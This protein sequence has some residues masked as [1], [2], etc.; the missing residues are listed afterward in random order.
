[1]GL[2]GNQSSRSRILL[3]QLLNWSNQRLPKALQGIQKLIE[4]AKAFVESK[5]PCPPSLLQGLKA[6]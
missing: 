4:V 2:R 6:V 1:M 5:I 3:K